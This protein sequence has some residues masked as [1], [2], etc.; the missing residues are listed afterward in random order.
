MCLRYVKVLDQNQQHSI[1]Y[2]NKNNLT[3]KGDDTYG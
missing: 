2:L 3:L 1:N